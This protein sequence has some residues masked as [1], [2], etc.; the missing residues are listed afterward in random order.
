MDTIK[1][2]IYLSGVVR[3]ELAGRPEYG[4]MKTPNMGNRIPPNSQWFADNGCFS[5]KG[6][7]GFNLDKYLSWLQTQPR[8]MCIGATAPDKVGDAEETLRRSLPVLP[9]LRAIGYKAALVAQDGLE[10]LDIPWD[11][12]DVLFIGGSTEWKLSPAAAGLIAEA[13]RREKW[14]HMGR[15]NSLKRFTYASLAGCDSVDG[16]FLAFGPAKNLPILESWVAKLKERFKNNGGNNGE[17]I[18]SD[19][20]SRPNAPRL[21][22]TGE[23]TGDSHGDSSRRYGG[24]GMLG[25]DNCQLP[26][27]ELGNGDGTLLRRTLPAQEDSY[28]PRRE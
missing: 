11:A 16:T 17:F 4:Y 27:P 15:V 7:R 6:E 13:K 20:V 10:N 19:S 25:R 1:V 24:P 9:R 8:D 5:V 28:Y 23:S 14:V 3:P 12:F 2:P 18:V 22:R 26:A 21:P